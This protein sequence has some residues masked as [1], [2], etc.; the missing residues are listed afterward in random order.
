MNIVF[1]A[2]YYYPHIG[3]VER[4]IKELIKRLSINKIKFIIITEKY[5]N[6]LPDF[7]KFDNIDVYR[8]K[9]PKI[10]ILGLIVLWL[11][12][13]RLIP[14]LFKADLIHIHD[15][16][17]WYLPLRIIFPTKPVYVTFHGYESYPVNFKSKIYRKIAE[18]LCR[19]NICIGRFMKKWY[20]TKPSIVTYGAVD[21][22]I[23]SARKKVINK[24]DAVFIGRLDEQTGILEYAKAIR[25][26]KRTRDFKCLILGDGEYRKIIKNTGKLLGFVNNPEKYISYAKYAFVS[27]YLSI[28]EA[29]ASKKL[30]F[31]IYDNPIKKDY[32]RMTPFSKWIIAENDYRTL[33]K[34]L[35]YYDDNPDKANLIIQKAYR[36]VEKQ[37]WDCLANQYLKLWGYNFI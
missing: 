18:K 14:I 23:F 4:H 30:V 35:I 2:N 15:V 34:K 36:W 1:F 9:Y 27:R 24:Y 26:L 8:I 12:L 6:S 37:T 13:F 32:L 22:K 33:A 28:L 25:Y 31:S 17:I 7:E 19:G 10:K 16:F 20:G 29:F 3:G 21:S 11:K 5:D